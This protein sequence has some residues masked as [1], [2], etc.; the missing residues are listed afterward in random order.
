M[1]GEASPKPKL[2]SRVR[3][4]VHKLFTCQHSIVT[5][6]LIQ[7]C[8]SQSQLTDGNGG[9]E[10]PRCLRGHRPVMGLLTL[11]SPF[12][13]SSAPGAEIQLGWQHL[14][15]GQ[16]G[17]GM[18]LSGSHS[19]KDIFILGKQPEAPGLGWGAGTLGVSVGPLWPGQCLQD[20]FSK[21]LGF[22]KHPLT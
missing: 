6:V 19:G 18:A 1:N 22:C 11:Y 3:E 21:G 15:E 12:P 8:A 17:A 13:P 14:L 20:A 10:R 16:V 9:S 7:G 2:S 5:P 4:K